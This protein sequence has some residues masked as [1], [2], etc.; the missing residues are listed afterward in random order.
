MKIRRL[1]II[2]FP[3]YVVAQALYSG[4]FLLKAKELQEHIYTGDFVIGKG[5]DFFMFAAGDSVGAGVGASS[6]E[7]SVVGRTAE[8]IAKNHT[9]KL[10]NKSVSGYK[11]DDLLRISLPER[12]QD[13]ILLV[14]GSNNLFHFTDINRFGEDTE[15]VLRQYSK[16]AKKVI[17]IGPGRVFDTDAIPLI[18][19]PIYR[20]LAPKYA[21]K[22]KIAS[23][24]FD[25]V[26]YI[27]PIEAKLPPQLYGDTGAAD[28]FHPNDSG[29]RFWFDLLK[30]SL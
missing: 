22:M 14:I 13:L 20:N 24:K 7:T 11:M 17:I 21:E 15:T 29:H 19:R 23:L 8:F 3:V 25:N 28:H 18:L 2:L 1:L 16:K 5:N 30:S 12:Q 4:F 10:T 9:V 6:F 27:N 26:I